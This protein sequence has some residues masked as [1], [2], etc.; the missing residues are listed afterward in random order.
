MSK[1]S[2]EDF[3]PHME[4]AATGG[5]AI[6]PPGYER[7]RQ[8]THM[9][10]NLPSARKNF[11]WMRDEPADLGDVDNVIRTQAYFVAGLM[12]YGRCYASSGPGIP[13]LDAKKV[14][15][16]SAD[17]IEVH[18]RLIELRNTIAAHT[19]KSDLVRLTLAAKDEPDRVIIRHLSTSALPLDELPDFLE[20]VAHTEHFVTVS[21]NK[22]LDHLETRIGKK[23]VLD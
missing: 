14:Y 15:N 2:E 16:G 1:I 12:A 4:A 6:D 9:L 13:T 22:Q 20:A 10:M 19:D 21:L 8:W 3:K 11:E 5:F 7:L 17:G 18:R 23:I